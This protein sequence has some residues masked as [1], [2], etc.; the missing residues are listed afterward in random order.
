MSLFYN[1]FLARSAEDGAK[2]IVWA[3]VCSG[4]HAGLVE[5]G[6]RVDVGNGGEELGGVWSECVEVWRAVDR[7]TVDAVLGC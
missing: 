6:V 4:E 3:A 7:A 1:T 5:A 2:G